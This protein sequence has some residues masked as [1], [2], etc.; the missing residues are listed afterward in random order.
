MVRKLCVINRL[1][2]FTVEQHV[3]WVEEKHTLGFKTRMSQV[4]S[5][6]KNV[7]L[8]HEVAVELLLV[9]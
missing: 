5:I 1:D 4:C 8:Q 9:E 6:V 3:G 2:F 7:L